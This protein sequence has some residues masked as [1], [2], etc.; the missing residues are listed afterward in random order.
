MKDEIKCQHRGYR[1]RFTSGFS[2]H[3]CGKFIPYGT[4]EHFRE[5]EANSLYWALHNV[6]ARFILGQREKGLSPELE[7]L[8]EKLSYDKIR[9]LSDSEI[10]KLR[11]EAYSLFDKYNI[12]RR[13]ALMTIK[14]H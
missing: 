12:S 6:R 8:Q 4:L 10:L 9:D 11:D 13:L 7:Q 3:E 1:T 5:E 14:M 2:C